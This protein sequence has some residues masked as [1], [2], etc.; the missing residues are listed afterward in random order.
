MRK[1]SRKEVGIYS[2]PRLRPG[3]VV[4]VVPLV[5]CFCISHPV[6]AR[7]S[8]L[9]PLLLPLLV[10]WPAAGGPRIFTV[11][12]EFRVRPFGAFDSFPVL[13]S[14]IFANSELKVVSLSGFACAMDV[15]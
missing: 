6:K 1:S 13:G 9:P 15:C 8:S 14:E 2:L 3:R 5:S 10:A 12:L 4:L 7:E 11:A